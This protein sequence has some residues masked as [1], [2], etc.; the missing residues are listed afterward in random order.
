ML[1]AD[2]ASAKG[3]R[4]GERVLK[5]AR[6]LGPHANCAGRTPSVS[7]HGHRCLRLQ[8]RLK[9]SHSPFPANGASLPLASKVFGLT[10]AGHA[11]HTEQALM[12]GPP[13]QGQPVTAGPVT[14][15]Q[16]DARLVPT[17]GQTAWNSNPA[18]TTSHSAQ[19]T[20]SCKIP[21]SMNCLASA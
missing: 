2:A 3:P 19:A 13:R 12:G 5:M 15:L 17:P 11:P 1:A 18:A 21:S 6:A 8:S 20:G 9:Q 10:M 7:R 16:S 14:G 4:A